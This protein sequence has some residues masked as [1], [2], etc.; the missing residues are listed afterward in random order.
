VEIGG[1]G[2]SVESDG[3][4]AVSLSAAVVVDALVQGLGQRPSLHLEGMLSTPDPGILEEREEPVVLD[5]RTTEMTW[6][7]TL[8]EGWC[9]P[10]AAEQQVRNDV[11]LFRQT[12]RHA[13]ASNSFDVL[14]RVE[15]RRRWIEPADLPALYELALAEHRTQRRRIRL[16]CEEA[17]T[18]DV[19]S[20][21]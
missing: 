4:P 17:S 3:V 6:H 18:P 12:I 15:L 9:R 11:G 13:E 8:P 16:A 2:W 5:P 19:P 20:S 10:A 14:R 21:S 1:V 7:L